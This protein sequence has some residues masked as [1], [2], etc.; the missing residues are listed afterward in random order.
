MRRLLLTVIALGV[1]A[2]LAA[3]SGAV[4][5]VPTHDSVTGTLF[6]IVGSGGVQ[7]N[8][9]ASSGPSGESPT[10]SIEADVFSGGGGTFTVNFQV[11]CLQVAANRAVIGG[12]ATADATVAQAYLVVVDEPGAVQDRLLDQ[13][14]VNDPTAPATCAAFD[15]QTAGATPP[16]AHSGSI[17]VIDAQPFPTSKDQCKNGGWRNFPG[18]K[19]QGDCVSFVATGGKTPPGS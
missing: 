17:V 5:Q 3:P 8:I 19:N 15:A 18:F 12:R 1:A 16:P 7:W 4:A 13:V 2:M 10:G 14:F 9:N 11:T 6:E